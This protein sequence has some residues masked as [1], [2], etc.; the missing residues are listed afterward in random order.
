MGASQPA[1]SSADL[2]D[3]RARAGAVEEILRAALVDVTEESLV[4]AEASQPAQARREAAR[5]LERDAELLVLLLAD[6]TRAVVHG[7]TEAHR[8]AAVGAAAVPQ[9]A[10]VDEDA[11]GLHDRRLGGDGLAESRRAVPAVAARHDARRAIFLREVAER[12]HA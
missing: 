4:E 3:H 7:Q 2:A 8:A 6:P 1:A 10:V 9:A 12:P 5:H 11:A